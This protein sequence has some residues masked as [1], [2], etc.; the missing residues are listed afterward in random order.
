MATAG[1]R[2]LKNH[3]TSY[4]RRARAGERVVITDRGE[5][6]AILAPLPDAARAETVEESLARLAGRGALSLPS[7]RLARRRSRVKVRGRP[8]SRTVIED[9]E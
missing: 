9:R 1:V 3:L 5:P 8:L 7:R 4:L 6:V 2:E